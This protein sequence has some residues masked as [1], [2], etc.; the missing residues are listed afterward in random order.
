VVLGIADATELGDT[1]P[2]GRPAAAGLP[3]GVL[4]GARL[5]DGVLLDTVLRGAAPAGRT[6]AGIA[7]GV[8]PMLRVLRGVGVAP[9][10]DGADVPPLPR[11]EGSGAGTPAGG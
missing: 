10:R 4:P 6:L 2:V 11:G 5:L 1:A 7:A 3:D 9:V 8:G